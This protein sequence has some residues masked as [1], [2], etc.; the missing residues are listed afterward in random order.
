MSFQRKM[1]VVALACAMPWMS[2]QAQSA[3]DLKKE[4]ES[5]KAQLQMLTQKVEAMSAQTDNTALVQQV[6]R[7]EQKQ[8]L[9]ADDQEKSGFKGL[10]I[11]GTIEAAFKFDD[12]A[13]SHNFSASS[14]YTDSDA[15]VGMIQITK[16]SQDGEGVDWTLRLLP[17][18][19]LYPV[20]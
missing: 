20:H 2:A 6:N 13:Q 3:A 8:E 16:E 10:K 19:T 18:S 4:I 7:I 17:G 15:G 5:L 14:G 11:N 12:V 1:L 9:A